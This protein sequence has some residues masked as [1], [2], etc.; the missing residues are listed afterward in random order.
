MAPIEVFIVTKTVIKYDITKGRSP[1]IRNLDLF[2][3]D[4]GSILPGEISRTVSIIQ[5]S[6]YYN[7][8]EGTAYGE[9][10][11]FMGSRG[12]S[13]LTRTGDYAFVAVKNDG[14]ERHECIVK[15]TRME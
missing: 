3:I 15:S 7:T 9:I 5:V 1:T 10:T 8:A 11:S 2:S 12:T 14:S 4:N 13:G 6:K